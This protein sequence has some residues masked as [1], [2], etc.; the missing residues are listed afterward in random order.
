MQCV[1]VDVGEAVKAGQVQA[2]M[3]PIDLNQLAMAGDS[4]LARA[5]RIAAAE[6]QRRNAPVRLK[7]T[8]SNARR[9]VELGGHRHTK[10]RWRQVP[11]RTVGNGPFLRHR[12]H[13]GS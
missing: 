9:Y 12:G 4:A 8:D 7:L 6:A 3:D 13:A 1:A 11:G 5:S 2:E 10:R